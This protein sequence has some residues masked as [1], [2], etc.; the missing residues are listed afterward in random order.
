MDPQSFK[1]QVWFWMNNIQLR[2]PDSVVLLVGTHCDQCRDQEEVMEKKKDIEEKVRIML[3]NRKMVLKHQ[4]KNLEENMDA[5]LFTDQLDELDCLLEY[6]LKVFF[7]SIRLASKI[8]LIS[9]YLSQ[10]SLL[11]VC[12]ALRGRTALPYKYIHV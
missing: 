7:F 12:F 10:N 5:S 8:F 6:N 1:D 4:K 9:L 2:V 3:A 11:K